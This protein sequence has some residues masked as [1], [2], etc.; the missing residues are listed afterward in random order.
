MSLQSLFSDRFAR[1]AKGK[2]HIFLWFSRVWVPMLYL[3]FD[4][5]VHAYVYLSPTCV[6]YNM[7]SKQS[8]LASK[9]CLR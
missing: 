2:E 6:K 5:C 4:I 3:V 8:L 7:L 9:G 1:L